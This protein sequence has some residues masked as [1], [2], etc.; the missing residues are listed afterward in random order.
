MW[1]HAD[2]VSPPLGNNSA[3]TGSAPPFPPDAHRLEGILESIGDHLVTYDREWRYTYINSSGAR[4]LGKSVEELLGRSIWDVFPDA[5]GGAYYVGMHEAVATQRSIR[6][7][8]YYAPWE[9]WFEN[10][11]YPTPDGV[12]VFAS[13]ITARKTA[14]A[15][16][17]AAKEQLA[18]YA[19]DLEAR[20]EERT[21]ELQDKVS[22]LEAFSYTLS[23][24]L[25]APLRAMRGFARLVAEEAGPKLDARSNDYLA[26]V[27]SAGE[28]LDQLI[29]DALAYSRV[30]SEELS[31]GPIALGPIVA[32]L[33]A[34]LPSLQEP[35]AQVR[36]V[37]SLGVVRGHGPLLTQCVVNLLD[38]AVKFTAP[39]VT[40]CVEISAARVDSMARVFV[41]DNGLGVPPAARERIFSLF[42]R[43]HSEAGY[44]G[45]GVGLAIVQRAITRMGGRV[46]VESD[47]V[48]GSTFW[49]ELPAAD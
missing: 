7:E 35:R 18:R 34:Q 32:S 8:S 22:E 13:D 23:H 11:I 4:L 49:F 31:L 30:G 2:G 43:A 12:T 44:P 41:R 14:E 28:R 20:V 21:R 45:T 17:A 36:I 3:R 16:L 27:E 40:P 24:D 48:N 1:T 42:A 25:R 5:V 29:A 19:Q 47:G 26:R 37:G 46:G 38:N 15:Q 9:R 33:V 6:Q 10:Y 39:A